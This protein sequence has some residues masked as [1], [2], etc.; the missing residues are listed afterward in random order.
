[1]RRYTVEVNHRE[2]M[3]DVEELASDRFRV[4]LGGQSY[5]VRLHSNEDIA[6]ARITPEVL[7]LQVEVGEDDSSPVAP[8]EATQHRAPAPESLPPLPASRPPGLPPQSNIPGAEFRLEIVAPMPGTIL[9]VNVSPGDPVKRG[10]TVLILEAM[11]MKNAI[12]APHEGVVSNVLVQPGQT[13]S[14]G[15]V[16][17]E[18]ERPN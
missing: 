17:V 16:L 9:T 11:K 10:Q 15:H 5:E 1:M 3:I 13:V 6:G 4:Q 12:K 18:F 7:P 8:V 14:Y 2:Y